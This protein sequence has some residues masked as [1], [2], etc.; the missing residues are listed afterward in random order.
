VINE[1]KSQECKI[2][3]RYCYIR[4]L[5]SGQNWC[6]PRRKERVW[7]MKED[8]RV[9]IIRVMNEKETEYRWVTGEGR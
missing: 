1:G 5:K 4:G 2:K 6:C 3:L 7:P 8:L 9:L